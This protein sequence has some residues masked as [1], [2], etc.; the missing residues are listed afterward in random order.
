MG[1]T[2]DPTAPITDRWF[3]ESIR[4]EKIY[5]DLVNSI[6]NMK[7]VYEVDGS[8]IIRE[9]VYTY[10]TTASDWVLLR[11]LYYLYDE[12]GAPIGMRVMDTEGNLSVYYYRKNLQGDVLAVMNSAGY[13]VVTYT[14]DAWGRIRSTEYVASSAYVTAEDIENS[15]LNPFRYRGYYYDSETQLYYLQSRYYNPTWGR[16]LNAD[17]YI[18]ANGDLLGYNMF[19]YCGNNPVMYLDDTGENPVGFL[20]QVF[21]SIVSYAGI[22]IASIFNEDVRNDMNDIDWNP[23]NS[24]ESLVTGSTSV[25]FYK[26]VPVF[27]TS[28]KRSGSFGAIF[29]VQNE[30]NDIVQHEF[31]HNVQ[32]MLMDPITYGLMIFI[33]SAAELGNRLY[34]EKPWEISAEMFGGVKARSHSEQDIKRGY[35]YFGISA[36]LGPLG[37]LFLLGEY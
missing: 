24:D 21:I 2:E 20:T 18:N 32:Q 29:L 19:A 11:K 33:P 22:A 31:G 7:H 16:F 23:F 10:D 30:T 5:T 9:T 37:Y 8:T 35:W 13:D 17:G 12:N 26:G 6:G 4:T 25:S 36:F 27:R 14:Y 34:Y 3:V 1:H 28:F 15:R